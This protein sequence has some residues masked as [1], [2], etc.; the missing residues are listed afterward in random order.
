MV[1]PQK[2]TDEY[3]K[4][5]NTQIRQRQ[6]Q[7]KLPLQSILITVSLMFIWEKQEEFILKKATLCFQT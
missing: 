1:L 5:K 3:N 4:I 2:L 7:N 6:K